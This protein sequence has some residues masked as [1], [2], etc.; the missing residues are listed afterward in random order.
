[1]S[2]LWGVQPIVTERVTIDE[3]A[4]ELVERGVLAAGAVAVFINI[5]P[6]QDRTDANFLHVRQVGVRGVP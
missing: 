4:A 2:L 1:M 6:G 5:S 3:L